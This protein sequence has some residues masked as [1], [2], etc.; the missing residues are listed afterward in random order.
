MVD[1]QG[2][3]RRGAQQESPAEREA[4]KNRTIKQDLERPPEGRDSPLAETV[5]GGKRDPKNPWLGG[6]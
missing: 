1:E 2:D 6:G 4:K 5:E 3:E